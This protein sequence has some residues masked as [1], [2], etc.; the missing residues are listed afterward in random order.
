[1][2]KIEDKMNNSNK[3]IYQ[4]RLSLIIFAQ[5]MLMLIVAFLLY[6]NF[7]QLERV[8]IIFIFLSLLWAA[9]VGISYQYS[10]LKITKSEVV[11]KRGFLVREITIIPMAKI[12]SVDITQ[13]IIGAIFKYGSI[14]IT[15]SGGTRQIM[16]YISRPLTVRRY[17][18]QL[19]AGY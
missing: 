10:L 19:I 13:S 3:I 1:M 7:Y 16:H 18:E 5:P 8:G 17:I 14:I 11:L 12:E 2:F 9:M 4:A 6:L 15:G